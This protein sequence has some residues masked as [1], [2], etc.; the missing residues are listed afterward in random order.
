MRLHSKTDSTG[1]RWAPASPSSSR[2][3][4]I[5]SN[6]PMPLWSWATNESRGHASLAFSGVRALNPFNTLITCSI[7]TQRHHTP[8][9]PCCLFTQRYMCLQSWFL[10][11]LSVK[12][13][14]DLPPAPGSFWL[15]DFPTLTHYLLSVLIISSLK[16]KIYSNQLSISNFFPD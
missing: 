14:Q 11:P 7:T 8:P 2:R 5:C 10:H 16:W 13:P 6:T 4:F 9:R 15:P 1:C 12:L 3:P